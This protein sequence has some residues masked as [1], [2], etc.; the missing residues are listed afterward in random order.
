[1][2]FRSNPENIAARPMIPPSSIIIYENKVDKHKEHH[3]SLS[4][5]DAP[6]PK[7]CRTVTSR[8]TSVAAAVKNL[9]LSLPVSGSYTWEWRYKRYSV[10]HSPSRAIDHCIALFLTAHN[11]A[12]RIL[13]TKHDDD[14][15]AIARIAVPCGSLL[16]S[17]TFYEP[18][19]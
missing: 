7:G 5:F 6:N 16:R 11:V 1:M 15:I 9:S 18:S 19:N 17:D 3:G 10:I 12:K 2:V 13:G 8:T 14:L 4:R